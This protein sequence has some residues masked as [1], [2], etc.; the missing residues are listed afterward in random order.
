[1]RSGW[2]EQFSHGL[3]EEKM[4]EDRGIR[5]EIAEALEAPSSQENPS[6][7]SPILLSLLHHFSY[8]PSIQPLL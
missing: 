7:F 5:L 8:L 2:F 1:M 4:R 6:W 3:P